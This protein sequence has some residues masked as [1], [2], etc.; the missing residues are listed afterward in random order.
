MSNILGVSD[1]YTSGTVHAN[2][3]RMS[4]RS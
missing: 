4:V 3:T 1:Q 2:P